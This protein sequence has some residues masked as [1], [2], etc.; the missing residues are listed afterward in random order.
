MRT[1]WGDL[2]DDYRGL[3][4]SGPGEHKGRVLVGC[5]GFGLFVRERVPQG[6]KCG[7][8]HGGDVVRNEEAVRTPPRRLESLDRFEGRKPDQSPLPLLGRDALG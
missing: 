4:R 1:R 7:C 2:S 8:L 6:L 5:D 3:A